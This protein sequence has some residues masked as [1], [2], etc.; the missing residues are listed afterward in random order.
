MHEFLLGQENIQRDMP[1]HGKSYDIL[2]KDRMKLYQHSRRCPIAMQIFLDANLQYWRFI[3]MTFE[4]SERPE[5]K[6]FESPHL[7][8]QIDDYN[9]RSKD[10][11]QIYVTSVPRPPVGFTFSNRQIALQT[12]YFHK[13]QDKIMPNK[14]ID[15]YNATIVAVRKLIA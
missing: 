8:D 3:P 12:Q 1:A 2:V 4:E 10:D 14:D 13:K 7:S 9:R 6:F 11:C 15:L 5:Q